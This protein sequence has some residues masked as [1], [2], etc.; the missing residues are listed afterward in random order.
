M[1][2]PGAPFEAEPFLKRLPQKPGVYQ[3]LDVARRGAVRRQGAQSEEPR[4]QLLP[5]VGPQ[6]KDDGVGRADSRHRDHADVE[7]NRSA[8]ARA[9]PDQKAAAAIQHR[10]ARR[11]VISLHPSHRSRIPASCVSSRCEEKDRALFR[12][13][14]ERERRAREHQHPAAA[15]SA[16]AVRRQ[17]LQEPLAAVSAA[18]DRSLQRAVRA[19]WLRR[20][21]MRTTCVMR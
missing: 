9:E 7:R 13:V 1:R 12:A 2:D 15:V 20:R 6:R 16:A 18:S 19:S 21:A 5:C 8:A 10:P 3:M 17:L 4:H 14:S 11:Q